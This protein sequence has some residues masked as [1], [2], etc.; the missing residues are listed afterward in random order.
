M[1]IPP[2]E[3]HAPA[4]LPEAV[5][6]LNR[7]DPNAKIVAGGTDLLPV[8]KSRTV[9]PSAVVSLH[10]IKDLDYVVKQNG[11]IRVGAL[12]LHADLA[13]SR[14]V[15]DTIP[16]LAQACSLIGSWQIRNT[17]TIGGNLCNASPVADTA[18]PL[19]T[20]DASVVLQSREGSREMTLHKFFIG[21]GTTELEPGELLKEV[22]IPLPG[23]GSAGCYLKLMRRKALDLALVS[24]T[25]QAEPGPDGHTLGKVAIALGGVAPTPIRVPGAEDL[26]TGLD[27]AAA[28]KAV[29]EASRI[30]V[31]VSNPIS[32]VRASA[33]YR[34]MITETYMDKG[35]MALIET[36]NQRSTPS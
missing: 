36:L 33:D 27:Y 34:R 29:P 14:L 28:K 25:I 4:S 30:A 35:L 5:E 31:A 7:L 22:R 20:L 21:P 32:D 23:I 9:R 6:V 8:L 15:K 11:C 1:P 24:V 13:E 26:L 3:F 18:G 2:F 17:A 12:A 16:I 10:A 19:L